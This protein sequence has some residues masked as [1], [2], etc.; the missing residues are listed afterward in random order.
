MNGYFCPKCN[1]CA[2]HN[3]DNLDNHVCDLLLVN[4]PSCIQNRSWDQLIHVIKSYQAN[5]GRDA[6]ISYVFDHIVEAFDR[7][8]GRE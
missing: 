3:D 6:T 5:I 7:I 4:M 2:G 8:K 1:W